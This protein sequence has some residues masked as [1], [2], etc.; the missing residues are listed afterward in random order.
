MPIGRYTSHGTAEGLTGGCAAAKTA[1]A[2]TAP[3]AP[4]LERQCSAAAPP[5]AR[6]G[7]QLGRVPSTGT[8]ARPT[9][10]CDAA[11]SARA[12][13]SPAAPDLERQC[14]A[15]LAA[16]VAPAPPAPSERYPPVM[17]PHDF[18]IGR[19]TLEQDGQQV[20]Q[21][22]VGKPVAI[23]CSYFVNEANSFVLKIRP[24][25]GNIYI[26]GQGAPTLELQSATSNGQHE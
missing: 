4:T 2:R 6:T 9:S 25:R 11:K 21:P 26:G 22:V 18:V 14:N 17:K 24:W 1:R 3:A 15:Y 5:P 10:L 20:T 12:R 13:N 8:A 19:I 23:S 16:N 7:L